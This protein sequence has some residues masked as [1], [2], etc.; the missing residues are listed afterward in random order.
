M[1]GHLKMLGLKKAPVFSKDQL[2]A[3]L[4]HLAQLRKV[5]P[6]FEAFQS[7]D[8]PSQSL[9]LKAHFIEVDASAPT[10]VFMPGTNAYALLYGEFLRA[11]TERGFNV[12]GFDPRGHGQ[13]EGRRGSYTLPE[14]ISD[15]DSVTKWSRQRFSGPLFVSGSSQGGITAFYYGARKDVAIDGVICHN[16]ADLS[17]PDSARLT[18]FPRLSRLGSGLIQGLGKLF[19]ECPVPMS[20]YLNLER[21]PVAGIGS[22]RSVLLGDPLTV[23]FT[24][25]K[26]LASLA[27]EP[28]PQPL[29]DYRCPLLILQA[30]ADNIFPLDYIQSIYEEIAGPKELKIY[31]GLA[32]YMIVDQ[33]PVFIDD[34]SEW[35]LST[36]GE[37][38]K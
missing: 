6:W 15:L 30:E 17:R 16:L 33:V 7:V 34:V 23:P 38:Q 24:R 36:I 25:L 27:S 18:R 20:F 13:S 29:K 8:I 2:K 28:L 11:L 21:E 3:H 1:A 12:V 19:P 10:I 22:A 4:D 32:H 5:D 31:P 14:L 37:L 26:T 35:L 9:T